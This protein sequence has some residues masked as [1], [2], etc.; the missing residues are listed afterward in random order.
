MFNFVRRKDADE[1]CKVRALRESVFRTVTA[2]NGVS[3]DHFLEWS[4]KGKVS[5]MTMS[6]TL[7][8]VSLVVVSE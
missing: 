7:A 8:F 5:G 1:T 6:L 3:E 4:S 2:M